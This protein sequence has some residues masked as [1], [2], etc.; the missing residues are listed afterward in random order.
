MICCYNVTC[1]LLRKRNELQ[2]SLKTDNDPPDKYSVY[3]WNVY[4]KKEGVIFYNDSSSQNEKNVSLTFLQP[5]RVIQL[6]DNRMQVEFCFDKKRK[7]CKKRHTGW[8]NLHDLILF[9]A[10]S[11]RFF[12]AV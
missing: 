12:R 5:G 6:N 1:V 11:M 2:R 3:V 10:L 8:V 9:K 4:A 7:S